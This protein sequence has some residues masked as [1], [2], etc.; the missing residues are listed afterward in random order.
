MPVLIVGSSADQ[1]SV[2]QCMRAVGQ[3]RGVTD[4]SERFSIGE[5]KALISQAAV[6]ISADTGP[7]YI[8]EAFGV[9]TVDVVGPVSEQDQPPR[10][11]QHV[12]VVP[13]RDRPALYALNARLY[14]ATEARRQAAAS[15][16]EEVIAAIDSLQI[17]SHA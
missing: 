12:V 3:E 2:L 10:G 1:G 9:P 16:V 17:H 11:P 7:L 13:K 6:F 8:A 5:L 15:S 4:V 14:D